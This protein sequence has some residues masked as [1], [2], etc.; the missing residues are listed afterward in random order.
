M[1]QHERNVEERKKKEDEE[2]HDERNNHLTIGY[3]IIELSHKSIVIFFYFIASICQF[4][5]FWKKYPST[6]YQISRTLTSIPP[7]IDICSRNDI[8]SLSNG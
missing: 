2:N 5:P 1:N 6:F 4:N 3:N 8:R 7:I